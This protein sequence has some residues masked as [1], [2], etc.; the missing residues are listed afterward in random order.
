M[1]RT[2]ATPRR[3]DW[4]GFAVPLYEIDYRQEWSAPIGHKKSERMRVTVGHFDSH[5]GSVRA[6]GNSE[7]GLY[8]TKTENIGLSDESIDVICIRL[9]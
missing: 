6:I 4:D 5:A 3:L 9:A 1:P 8:F 2:R 7:Q